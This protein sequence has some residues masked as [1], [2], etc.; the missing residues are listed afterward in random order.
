MEVAGVEDVL[1]L[2]SPRLGRRAGVGMSIDDGRR[3]VLLGR[4]RG[5]I[6]GAG[7]RHGA[8]PG[9]R[10]ATVGPRLG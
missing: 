6:D 3:L 7:A 1:V 2:R 10:W 9:E 5:R 8:E 4:V